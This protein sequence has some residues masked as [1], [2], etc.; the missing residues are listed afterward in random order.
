MA[1]PAGS[2]K[3]KGGGYVGLA[4]ANFQAIDP[5]DLVETFLFFFVDPSHVF[6]GT[7]ID[8][9]WFRKSK[10]TRGQSSSEDALNHFWRFQAGLL[11]GQNF[12]AFFQSRPKNVPK[13][14][15]LDSQT[16]SRGYELPQSDLAF[17]V[18][19]I[20]ESFVGIAGDDAP[21]FQRPA[22]TTSCSSCGRKPTGDCHLRLHWEVWHLLIFS[23]RE[24]SL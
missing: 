17:F 9:C 15:L 23:W 5:Q 12:H 20:A 13:L 7:N 19:N 22:P 24:R 4:G 10:S 8:I 14:G 21:K 16:K 3:A 18:S 6:V 11:L 1:S 2:P